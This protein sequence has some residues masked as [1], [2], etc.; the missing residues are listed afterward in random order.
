MGKR[1]ATAAALTFLAITPG[2]IRGQEVVQ[3]SKENT[4]QVRVDEWQKQQ[5][6]QKLE[7]KI[8]KALNESSIQTI[9]QY[10]PSYGYELKKTELGISNEL[11]ST[12]KPAMM[13]RTLLNANDSESALPTTANAVYN[14]G[15][16]ALAPSLN[17][18]LR[19]RGKKDALYTAMELSY[20]GLNIADYASTR[21]ALSKGLQEGNPVMK[22]FVKKSPL[23]LAF[24]G[25]VTYLTLRMTNK[26]YKRD[27]PLATGVMIA[28]NLLCGYVVYNNARLIGR[29]HKAGI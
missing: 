23:D 12:P 28:M 26:L 15:N 17:S 11:Y 2:F 10:P 5:I 20:I 25:V 22:Y 1:L 4:Y 9:G 14:K 29:Q 7:E 8:T 21:I 18:P 19:Y 13:I 6:N 27:K 16:L 24:K 3:P